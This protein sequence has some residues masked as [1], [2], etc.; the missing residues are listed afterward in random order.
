MERK[1]KFNWLSFLAGI[2]FIIASIFILKNPKA[3]IISF[4]IIAIVRGIMLIGAYSSVKELTT[5]RLKISLTV[6]ILFVIIGIVLLA[7]PD[8]AARA[9]AYLV[10]VW[11]IAD[12]INNLI[13]SSFVRPA[14]KSLLVAWIICSILLLA[15]GIVLLLHPL[16]VGRS[17]T[18]LVALSLMFSGI[19]YIIFAFS[20]PRYSYY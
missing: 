17:I 8:F 5:L 1:G 6:G 15:G 16:I 13:N 9:Y 11:F 4:G 18:W 12:A 2:I 10:A 20:Y 14:G 7:W 19:D 3:L